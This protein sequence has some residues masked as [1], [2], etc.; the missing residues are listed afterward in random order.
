MNRRARPGGEG[1]RWD[2]AAAPEAEAAGADRAATG[3]DRATADS[4]AVIAAAEQA[5]ALAESALEALRVLDDATLWRVRWRDLEERVARSARALDLA[6]PGAGPHAL[7][8][9][10]FRLAN[11]VRALASSA[12]PSA[13]EG[14]SRTRRRPRWQM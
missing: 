6:L 10:E 12:P 4:E 2:G 13:L 1:G 7:G 8:G 5:L 14:R 3:A 9:L 11:L